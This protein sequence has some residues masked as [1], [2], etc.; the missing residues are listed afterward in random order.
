MPKIV[1]GRSAKKPGA[2]QFSSEGFH[3]QV[4]IEVP[5]DGPDQFHQHVRQLFAELQA[6]L[7]AEMAQ[8]GPH[9]DEVG[10]GSVNLWSGSSNGNDQRSRRHRGHSES[11]R[12]DGNGDAPAPIS[13]KQAA[14]LTQL[15]AKRG[16][17]QQSEIAHWL[18]KTLGLT[19][20]SQYDI[21]KQDASRAIEILRQPKA[22]NK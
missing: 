16:I 15:F 14:Y 9:R 19:A 5:L 4:E 12:R 11:G 1:V 2:E 3:V 13:N 10:S 6:A 17:S 22:S 8:T 18:H 21:S 7:D 20:S